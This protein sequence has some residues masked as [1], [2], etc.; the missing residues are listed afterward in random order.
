MAKYNT[1]NLLKIR[2]AEAYANRGA[3]LNKPSMTAFDETF[4][5]GREFDTDPETLKGYAE[6]LKSHRDALNH[7]SLQSLA[8]IGVVFSLPSL[9]YD[10]WAHINSWE[11]IASFWPI[12]ICRM[13]SSTREMEY[14]MP[15][16]LK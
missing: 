11:G 16:S 3:M 1:Q 10:K 4:M 5:R 6:F 2:F 15:M 8:D 7:E 9:F 14:T 13:R 12:F